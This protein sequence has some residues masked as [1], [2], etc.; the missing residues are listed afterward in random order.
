[1]SSVASR[2]RAPRLSSASTDDQG[3]KMRRAVSLDD[4]TGHGR[5]ALADGDDQIRDLARSARRSVSRTGRPITW[6][7]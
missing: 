7:K 2:S 5:I 3:R 1:M 6:L 4:E